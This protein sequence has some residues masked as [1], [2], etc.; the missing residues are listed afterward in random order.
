M[1]LEELADAVGCVALSHH[2]RTDVRKDLFL[3][4][5][6]VVHHLPL[7]LLVNRVKYVKNR[8]WTTENVA[9]NGYELTGA[10][11][12]TAKT[13]YIDLGKWVTSRE[14]L[15]EY[16][17]NIRTKTEYRYKYRTVT[18]SVDIIW[19]RTN[20]GNGYEPTGNSRKVYIRDNRNKQK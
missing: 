8:I 10:T 20:P 18:N 15:G 19:S 6:E 5:H 11:K 16:T 9:I 4:V 13:T 1:G 3:L 14:L 17:Y 12:S 2:Q 7:V